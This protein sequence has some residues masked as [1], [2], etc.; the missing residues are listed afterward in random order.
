MVLIDHIYPLLRQKKFTVHVHS[1]IQILTPI[2]IVL[3]LMFRVL[4]KRALKDIR[5]NL[6]KLW[7]IYHY[8]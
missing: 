3:F 2:L 8:F 1:M 6:L 5:D 7:Y 4:G